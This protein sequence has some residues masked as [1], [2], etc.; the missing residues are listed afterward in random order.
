MKEKLCYL[1]IWD[2]ESLKFIWN[3]FQEKKRKEKGKRKKEARKKNDNFINKL[4]NI[5]KNNIFKI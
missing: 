1:K 4:F 3:S 2:R 5:V